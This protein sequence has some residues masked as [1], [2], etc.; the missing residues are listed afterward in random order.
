MNDLYRFISDC[1]CGDGVGCNDAVLVPVT[2]DYAALRERV[3]RRIHAVGP[4]SLN[5]SQVTQ[6]KLAMDDIRAALESNE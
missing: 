3:C 4:T 2:I 5:A 6:L 1:G